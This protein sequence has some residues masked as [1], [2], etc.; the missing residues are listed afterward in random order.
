M[1]K[2]IVWI[3]WA[4]AIGIMIVVYC[5]IPQENS[6]FK[7][8]LCSFQMPLF[9]M[10][11]GYLHKVP[12]GTF[13]NSIKK[14]WKTLIIPYFLFQF[15][16]YPYWLVQQHI[17]KELDLTNYM[18]SVITPFIHCL[19]GISI[20]GPVWFIFALLLTKIIADLSLKNSRSTLI[21]IFLCICSMVGAWF[22][23]QD[24]KLN[25]TFAIDS[26]SNFF[27][28]FFIGYYLKKYDII[29]ENATIKC[30]INATICFIISYTTINYS[31]DSY[32][33]QRISFYLLGISGSFFIIN[34]CKL[35]LNIP[36]IIKTISVG[37]IIILGL[38]WMFIGTTNY[39]LESLLEIQN[40]IK[41]NIFESILLSLFIIVINAGIIKLCQKYFKALLGYR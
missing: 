32:L 1:K 6:F 22:I 3:D 20:N 38:H 7:S 25:I 37:T 8:F 16:Y 41:Y 5:H 34:I 11:A 4:K 39:I 31:P 26:L 21:I 24:D 12:Q 19:L 13:K 2:R 30:I 9:F 17:Q 18:D 40:G 35:P 10:I 14:Y 28:F 33:S 15:I 29:K 23:W 36:H 27:P